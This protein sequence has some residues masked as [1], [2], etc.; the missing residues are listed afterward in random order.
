M[1]LE[2]SSRP[3]SQS[4]RIRL[5]QWPVSCLVRCVVSARHWQESSSRTKR[6]VA[7]A[8]QRQFINIIIRR[9]PNINRVGR[10]VA[11]WD[12]MGPWSYS[13][14]R[15]ILFHMLALSDRLPDYHTY[16]PK[17]RIF[18][19]D[20]SVTCSKTDADNSELTLAP[21]PV[22][23]ARMDTT[24]WAIWVSSVQVRG[25]PG[26]SGAVQVSPSQS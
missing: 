16:G 4:T 14:R 17:S 9:V 6:T 18:L 22:Q 8:K 11:P 24:S 5:V 13:G 10:L 15:S 19:G 2:L 26:Q 7:L 1:K 3:L 25:S 23:G 20:K 21:P 12:P